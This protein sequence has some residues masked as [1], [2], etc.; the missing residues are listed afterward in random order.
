[1]PDVNVPQR[2]LSPDHPCNLIAGMIVERREVP[3]RFRMLT[4]LSFVVLGSLSSLH[5]QARQAAP[6]PAKPPA[7]AAKPATI[8]ATDVAVTVNYTGKG[9]VDAKHSI[10]LFLFSDPKIGPGSQPIGP[11]QIAQKN[12]ATVT[13]SGVT[14]KPVYIFAIYNE[15]GTYDGQSGPPPAGTPVG[16]YGTAKGPTGVTPGMKTPVKMTFTGATKFGQ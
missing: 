14:T 13:F 6:P 10:L 16:V 2:V 9:T 15:K 1:M 8:A 3:M 12:G 7:A 4:L 11:P 5:A